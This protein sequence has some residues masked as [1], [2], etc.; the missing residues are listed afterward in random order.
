MKNILLATVTLFTFFCS[1]A[2]KTQEKEPLTFEVSYNG[3]SH[4]VQVGD[5]IQ[6]GYGSYPDGSFMYIYNS[7][8]PQPMGK[9]NAR[10]TGT[11]S[12]VKYVK[13]T[14]QNQIYIKGKFGN[15]IVDLPQAV[16]KGEVTGFNQTMFK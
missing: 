11:V 4:T 6:L 3:K 16:E 5:T 2:Q 1:Y 12:K 13:S 7:S 14:S 9:A 15:Y 10:K 8:P